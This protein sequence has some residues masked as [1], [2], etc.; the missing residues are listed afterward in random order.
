MNCFHTIAISSLIIKTFLFTWVGKIVCHLSVWNEDCNYMINIVILFCASPHTH[1]H[2][3]THTF[4]PTIS[5]IFIFII[6]I[7]IESVMDAF[8]FEMERNLLALIFYLL[9]YVVT[10]FA[11]FRS[12]FFLWFVYLSKGYFSKSIYEYIY[13][14]IYI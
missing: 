7:F 3:H 2:T 8:Q 11:H 14:Y 5:I 9:F 6:N 10:T 4:T 13:I 12:V 1:T